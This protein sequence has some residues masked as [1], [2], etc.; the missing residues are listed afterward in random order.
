MKLTY[1]PVALDLNKNNR[2]PLCLQDIGTGNK[3]WIV[4]LLEEGCPVRRKQQQQLLQQQ[5]SQ[6]IQ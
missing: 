2:C 3:G 6:Q 4:H 5:Q 1:P